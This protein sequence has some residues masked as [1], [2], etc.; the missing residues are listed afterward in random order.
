MGGK[1]RVNEHRLFYLTL[2]VV[3]IPGRICR[4][5][6]IDPRLGCRMNVGPS[7]EGLPSGRPQLPVADCDFGLNISIS[8]IV[9]KTRKDCR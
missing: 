9:Y 1:E 4:L 7:G 2:R 6:R 3:A 5:H 8:T